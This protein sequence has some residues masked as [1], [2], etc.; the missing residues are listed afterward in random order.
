MKHPFIFIIFIFLYFYIRQHVHTHKAA[1]EAIGP[2][3]CLV[4]G[5]MCAYT[6]TRPAGHEEINSR[7]HT[8][9]VENLHLH[10]HIY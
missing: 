6:C 1:Y 10:N 9:F 7:S 2:G 3:A 5:N 8:C 4:S